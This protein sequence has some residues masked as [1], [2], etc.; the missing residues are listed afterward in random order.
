MENT[1][2]NNKEELSAYELLKRI[3]EE[4][5]NPRLLT[6]EQRQECVEV[7]RLE[8]QTHG[9]IADM[10]KWNIKTI[11]RDW[12][13]VRSK[14]ATKPSP[15]LA[16]RMIAELIEKSG[17]KH[18]HLTRLARSKDGS[19]QEKSQAEFYAWKV[20][21]ET[22]QLLQSLGYL[23]NQAAKFVGEIYHH[24]DNEGNADPKEMRKEIERIEKIIVE[25]AKNDPA[26][27]AQL[28]AIK[29]KVEVI[30]LSQQI[31]DLS[32]QVSGESNNQKEEGK[33][34]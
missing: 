10:L 4:S 23:P 13:E 18:D 12:D 9:A 20:L 34:G 1:N 28:E 14:N 16:L 21:H 22:A 30:E 7:L 6:P 29:K 31:K 17:S 15:E 32:E 27:M 3:K 25:E 24:H 19:V 5:F 2:D 8:G 26:I 11:K 33:N